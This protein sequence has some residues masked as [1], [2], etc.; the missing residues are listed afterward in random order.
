MTPCPYKIAGEKSLDEA[1]HVM[2]LRN[3]R[4]LP[5]T[6]GEDIIGVVSKRDLEVSKVS[7]NSSKNSTSV[8]DICVGHPY[9]VTTETTV[10]EVTQVMANDKKECAL[11]IDEAGNF[12]GIFTTTDAC[13]LVSLILDSGSED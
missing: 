5:V 10:Q 6:S 12:V 3:I 8:A 13:K 9:V 1:L 2:E 7:G 11:V 4:H